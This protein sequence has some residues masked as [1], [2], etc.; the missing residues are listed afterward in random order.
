MDD[1]LRQLGGALVRVSTVPEEE[2]GE[3]RK[4]V[5]GEVGRQGGLLAFLAN[6]AD[7]YMVSGQEC[8]SLVGSRLV[9][10]H[11]PTSAA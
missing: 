5:D 10:L 11:S 9:M 1:E 7:A 4:L 2:L 6:D 8:L 3:V